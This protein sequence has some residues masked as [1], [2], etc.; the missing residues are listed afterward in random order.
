LQL[1]S[2]IGRQLIARQNL[3]LLY[4]LTGPDIQAGYDASIG[5]KHLPPEGAL[6]LPLKHD[7]RERGQDFLG[8]RSGLR[9]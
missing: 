6:E 2:D 5:H 7:I 9:L 1:L 3:S 4:G 8:R